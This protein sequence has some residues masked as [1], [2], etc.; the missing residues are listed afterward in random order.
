MV[1]FLHDS[2]SV[3]GKVYAFHK[4]AGWFSIKKK[5]ILFKYQK[6]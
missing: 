6:F 2:E 1:K 3:N 4:E 5:G